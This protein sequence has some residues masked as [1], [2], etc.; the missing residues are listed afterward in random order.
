MVYIK[1]TL[2]QSIIRVNEFFPVV[3]VTGPR[4]VGKTTVLQN[5]EKKPRTY[6]SLD[7]LA[8]RSLAQSDPQL[9]L[10]R[11]PAPVLIDEVQYAPQLF[12]YI[13]SIVDKEKKAGM[14]WLTGSQ[15]F[16]LMQNVTESLAGRVGVLNLNGFSQDEKRRTPITA[17]FLPTKEYI[18]SKALVAKQLGINEIYRL[19][20]RGSYPKMF[21][22][23]DELWTTFYDSYLQTY[24]ERDIKSLTSVGNNMAFVM[25]MRVLAARTGQVINYSDIA[26]DVGVSSPTIK[27]W[28]SILETSGLVFLLQPYYNNI[29]NRIIK[30]PK[31]YFMD[32]GLASFLAGWTSAEALANGAMNGSIFE[33]YV[34]S[35]IV[36]SYLYNGVK[37][38]LYYYRDKDGQ[39]IDLLIEENGKL[40]PV[41]IKRKSTPD[42]GDIKHFDVITN[43]LKKSRGEGA[44]V[45]AANTHLP[46][47]DDVTVIPVEY[48]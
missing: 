32:T 19:I 11:F 40:Y 7:T 27:S 9:F 16:H 39:E 21:G 25:F 20:W 10:E 8:N 18:D 46:L 6:V 26:R 38:N 30:S 5:C 34:V 42:K 36:K 3:L 24:V 15:Q 45:C 2:E 33:T 47:S 14:Y 29:T 35:E 13:K 37:P 48:L 1:R 44:V 4:Q 12:P 41:E 23:S 17:P 43:I 28:L 31:V 22:A